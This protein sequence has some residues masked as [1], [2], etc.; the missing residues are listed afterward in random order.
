MISNDVVIMIMMEQSVHIA[1]DLPLVAPTVNEP[2]TGTGLDMYM[3][4]QVNATCN[5]H[6]VNIHMLYK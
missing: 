3:L 4:S 1:G 6:I 5:I 2:Q